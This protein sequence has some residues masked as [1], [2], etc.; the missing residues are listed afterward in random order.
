MR[1][2]DAIAGWLATRWRRTSR[3][4]SASPPPHAWPR[5]GGSRRRRSASA[6]TVVVPAGRPSREIQ[7]RSTWA[8]ELTRLA[9]V[10]ARDLGERDRAVA[11]R[12]R[13]EDRQQRGEAG[14][15]GDQQR[16]ARLRVGLPVRARAGEADRVADRRAQRPRR[17]APDVAVQEDVDV[18]RRAPGSKLRTVKLRQCCSGLPSGKRQPSCGST[19][20]SPSCGQPSVRISPGCSIPGSANAGSWSVKRV[21]PGVS[22][23]IAATVATPVWSGNGRVIGVP[24]PPAAAPSPGRR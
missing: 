4:A 21:M 12:Q 7:R 9:L 8:R 19:S 20:A 11:G 22:G 24:G 2:R 5:S 18:D 6:S 17:R 15:V 14:L 1:L 3:I 13:L 10:V 23:S 16:P